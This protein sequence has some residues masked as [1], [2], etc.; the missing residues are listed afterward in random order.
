[1]KVVTSQLAELRNKI[2]EE[3]PDSSITVTSFL[4]EDKDIN[5]GMCRKEPLG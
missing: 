5:G 2:T 3:R 1:M 4:L